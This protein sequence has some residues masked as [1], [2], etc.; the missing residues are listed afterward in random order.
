[1]QVAISGVL[2][3]VHTHHFHD[4]VCT[5]LL[6]SHGREKVPA[7]PSNFVLPESLDDIF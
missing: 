7:V 2:I 1:M 4:S 6:N 3:K 5:T